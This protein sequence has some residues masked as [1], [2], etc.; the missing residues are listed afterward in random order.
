M[1]ANQGVCSCLFVR[2]A[3][4]FGTRNNT[5]VGYAIP[6]NQIKRFLPHFKK[7]G[8]IQHG[9]ITGLYVSETKK[10]GDGALVTRVSKGSAIRAGLKKGDIVIEAGGREITTFQCGQH[11]AIQRCGEIVRRANRAAG[12]Q[13]GPR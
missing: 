4:R 12:T 6:S 11:A 1:D 13:G 9:R 2:I 8:S 5:G 3:V 10:G 7:G